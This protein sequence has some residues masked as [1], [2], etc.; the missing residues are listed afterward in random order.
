MTKLLSL[1]TLCIVCFLS[2]SSLPIAQP[3]QTTA[4]RKGRA[5]LVGIN[6]YA[7]PEI[8]PVKGAEEDAQATAAFIQAQYKFAANEIHTLLGPRATR[9][10][11]LAE[12]NDWL[13]AETLPGDRVFFLFSGHGSRL[14]DDNSDEADGYDETIVPYDVGLDGTN[15]I[16]DDEINRLIAQLSGRLAVLV[17]DSC[18]S[19]TVSRGRS[20][21][22][23]SSERIEP[24]YLPSPEEFA[25]LKS[26]MR[27]VGGPAGSG[28]YEVREQTAEPSKGLVARNLKLVEEK[29][30]DTTSG[31]VVISAAQAGQLAY[32]LRLEDGGYRGALSYLFNELQRGQPPT[33]NQL[34][35]QL[36]ARIAALQQQ[37]RLK[38]SQI[39][40]FEIFARYPLG[41]LPLFAGAQAEVVLPVV[42]LAN[43]AS[44]IKVKLRSL[45][46]KTRYRLQEAISYEV[47]TSAPGYLYVLVFSRD[48]VATCVFPNETNADDRDNFVR[49]GTHR[50]PRSQRFYAQEPLGKDVVIAL[51]SS[52]KLNLGDK[53]DL[54]WN[55]VFERL[56]SKK[57]A[58]FVNQRG[59]GTKKPGQA[60]SAPSLDEADWQAASLVIETLR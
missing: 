27:A 21:T 50:I 4:P 59:V 56:R 28:D 24:R 43:P 8:N 44:T 16:R 54:T 17:F 2:S 31:I 37:G 51:V 41:D 19:G 26:G 7:H 58:G 11:I 14:R 6:R 10:N 13:I 34:R 35:E 3:T 29:L 12:F 38:G 53:E 30:A 15:Q 22:P 45:E 49:A 25:Q 48:N 40:A 60:A 42:A 9:A 33:V 46:G 47:T 23:A 52:I 1:T 32:P 36:A 55:E 20:G 5:L 18:H 39:P 57:L